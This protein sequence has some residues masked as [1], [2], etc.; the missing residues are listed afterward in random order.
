MRINDQPVPWSFVEIQNITNKDGSELAPDNWRHKNIGMITRLILAGGIR[1]LTP[2]FQIKIRMEEGKV[3]E[4][5]LDWEGNASTGP[6]WPVE[7]EPGIFDFETNTSIY[8]FRLL[9]E[10]EAEAVRSA[11]QKAIEARYAERFAMLQQMMN[12]PAGAGGGFPAS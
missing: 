10:E 1:R 3:V 6:D 7:V 12:P 4:L 11:V 5:D 2:F 8:R 9:S